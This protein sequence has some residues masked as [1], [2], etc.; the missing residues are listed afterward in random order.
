MIESGL[1][2]TVSYEKIYDGIF[3]YCPCTVRAPNMSYSTI[4][5]QSVEILRTQDTY[6]QKIRHRVYGR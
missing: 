1:S 5:G 6:M 3:Q 4:V 2:S